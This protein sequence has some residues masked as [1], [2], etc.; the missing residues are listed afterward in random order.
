MA[1]RLAGLNGMHTQA[2]PIP[3]R[4]HWLVLHFPT[5]EE[6]GE[7]MKALDAAQKAAK[8][9]AAR[10][11]PDPVVADDNE[12]DLAEAIKNSPRMKSAILPPGDVRPENII[13]YAGQDLLDGRTL[14]GVSMVDRPIYDQEGKLDYIDGTITVRTIAVADLPAV[15]PTGRIPPEAQ[16]ALAGLKERFGDPAVPLK[17]VFMGGGH[18]SGY[19]GRQVQLDQFRAGR[20]PEAPLVLG[21][22]GDREGVVIPAPIEDVID[23]LTENPSSPRG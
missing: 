3:G 15:E 23:A 17:D 18:A 16:A 20:E 13:V 7:A 12:A 21:D 14:V 10:P 5:P 1:V 22:E 4:G 8:A 19:S 6:A 9:A 2:D 11:G